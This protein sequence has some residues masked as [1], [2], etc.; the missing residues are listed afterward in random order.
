MQASARNQFIGTVS[1]VRIGNVNAEVYI[2]LNGGESIVASITKESV[3][4]LSIKTGIE[5]LALVKAPQ[6]IIVSDF[7]GYKI[8]ARNQLK[9]TITQ[10]KPGAVNAEV[11]IEL[12]GGEQVAAT[13]TN[14]SVDSLGLRKGQAVTAIFKAGAVILAVA[15]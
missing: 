11:D 10:V 6:I 13:V 9:G 2:S 1:E 5:V 12:G 3:E 15:R 8:S 14:D 4:T 7:G